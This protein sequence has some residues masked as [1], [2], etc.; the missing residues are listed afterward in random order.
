MGEDADDGIGFQHRRDVGADSCKD[1]IDGLAVLHVG[2]Q[3]AQR[4]GRRLGPGHRFASGKAAV[5]SGQQHMALAPDGYD[6]QP[7]G[8]RRFDIDNA[9]IE[10]EA[11]Q[12]GQ[13]FVGS[14]RQHLGRDSRMASGEGGGQRGDYRQRGGYDTQPQ[15]AGKSIAQGG[16]L[17]LQALGTRRHALGVLHHA[18]PLGRQS[19]ELLATLDHGDA[20]FGFEVADRRRQRGG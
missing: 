19:G 13:D 11:T 14:E 8:L 7:G 15:A 20:E 3:Q 12:P 16:Q 1:G 6:G 18:A 10:F 4:R 9:C 2:R 17:L 5:G